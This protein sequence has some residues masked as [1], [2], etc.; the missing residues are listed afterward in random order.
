[1]W[2]HLHTGSV[3]QYRA[4]AGVGDAELRERHRQNDEDHRAAEWQGPETQTTRAMRAGHAA[5]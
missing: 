1:M 3:S 5:A 2:R 4:R